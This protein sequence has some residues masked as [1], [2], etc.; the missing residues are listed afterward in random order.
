VG[1]AITDAAPL[2]LLLLLL[3]ER[4]GDS[5]LLLLLLALDAVLP[6]VP[7]SAAAVASV[8]MSTRGAPTLTTSP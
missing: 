2:L 3:L 4:E 1:A 6:A 5:S 8:W 7:C